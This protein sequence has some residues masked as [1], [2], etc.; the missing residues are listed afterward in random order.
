MRVVGCLLEYNERFVI[1]L[2]N[3]HKPDGNTWGLPGG[4]VERDETDMEAIVRELE[5]ETGYRARQTEVEYLG[6]FDFISSSNRPFTYV[7]FRV[8]L[9][10]AHNLRLEK[11]A[12]A[13]H[14]W[15]TARECYAKPDLIF[16]LHELLKMIGYVK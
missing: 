8:K 3:A 15:V 11:A 1:L 12:H 7:T 2:R 16:G 13:D 10:K 14:Q 9:H 4:K 6:N 5:E